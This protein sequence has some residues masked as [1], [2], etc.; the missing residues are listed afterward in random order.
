M[1][2]GLQQLLLVIGGGQ[3]AMML[4]FMGVTFAGFLLQWNKVGLMLSAGSAE[5]GCKSRSV[6]RG[7]G[8]GGGGEDNG[9]CAPLH[10]AIPYVGLR[11]FLDTP[12]TPP[13]LT[14]PPPCLR[15]PNLLSP[16][17]CQLL[18]C[19]FDSARDEVCGGAV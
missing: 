14:P 12:M 16:L 5:Q 15:L 3:L 4:P 1:S 17:R 11:R 13:P 7:G 8:G 9:S 18:L 19:V 10:P 2:S 6:W